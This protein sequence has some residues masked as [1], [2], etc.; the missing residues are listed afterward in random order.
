MQRF[1]NRVVIVTGAGS[2]IGQAAAIRIAE[3]GGTVACFDV[4]QAGLE[5]TVNSINAGDSTGNA[6]AWICD[7]SDQDAVIKNID[8]VV[9]QYSQ[10][11]ALCNVAGILRFDHTTEL[12]LDDW[13]QIINVNLTGTFLMCQSALPHLLKTRGSIVNMASTAALGAHAWTAAYSASKGGVFSLTKCLSVEYAKQGINANSVS[14]ASISTPMA[15][16]SV[17]PEGFDQ[18]L[19]NKILPFDG[20]PRPPSKIASVIAFLASDD[21]EHLNG[22]DIRADGGIMT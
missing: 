21:A 15:K 1:V 9:Q 7:V 2:G 8:E 11:N 17:L 22:I 20:P 5:E 13:N 19:L 3:E 10:L 18:S 6:K 14:P 16:A 4:N 12:K